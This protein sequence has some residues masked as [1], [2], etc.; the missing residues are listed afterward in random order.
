VIRKAAH[1]LGGP[2]ADLVCDECGA[3][4]TIRCD[5]DQKPDKRWEVNEGQALIKAKGLGWEMVKRKHYCPSCKAARKQNLKTVGSTESEQKL[6]IPVF[7]VMPAGPTRQVSLSS[8]PPIEKAQPNEA[9]S[10]ADDA[11][12]QKDGGKKIMPDTTVSQI[13]QPTV[14][15]NRMIKD[16]LDD[17]Y[18][19]EAGRYFGNESDH[20]VA[21]TLKAEGVMPAWVTSMR[22]TLYGAGAGNE[23]E[24][25]LSV[26]IPAML[27]G[28]ERRVAAVEE[29]IKKAVQELR[30][31][32][33]D[34]QKIKDLQSRFE[35]L[36][37]AMGP[38]A[39]TV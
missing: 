10:N 38:K 30:E 26:D 2:K 39:K 6:E 25:R 5:Y 21:E 27:D 9:C 36:K 19:V 13:R 22:E 7:P 23:E 1:G 15:H 18:D 24:E 32:E 33:K 12:K 11:K 29:T 20:S 8:V 3:V 35:R 37:A 28:I 14:K 4:T 34:R 16:L 31:I 17:V